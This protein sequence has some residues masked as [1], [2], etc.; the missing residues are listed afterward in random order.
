MLRRCKESQ[1][2]YVLGAPFGSLQGANLHQTEIDLIGRPQGVLK[3]Q[4]HS[5]STYTRRKR[6]GLMMMRQL[7][8]S[9]AVMI[10]E[11]IQ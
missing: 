9:E 10:V 11:S 6:T 3:N 2:R 1:Q 4:L 7:L 5:T 8:K